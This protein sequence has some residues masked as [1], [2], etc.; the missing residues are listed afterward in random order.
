MVC[1]ESVVA[2]GGKVYPPPAALSAGGEG[3]VQGASH[4]MA[5][6]LKCHGHGG[7]LKRREALADG[8]VS[9]HGR[10]GGRARGGGGG[11]V[12]EVGEAG[13]HFFGGSV[14]AGADFLGDLAEMLGAVALLGD[15][16]VER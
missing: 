6:A 8:G 9:R 11:V 5:V 12:G 14:F 4:E 16:A 1:V 15:G 13:F 2:M 3:G 10:S 7:R